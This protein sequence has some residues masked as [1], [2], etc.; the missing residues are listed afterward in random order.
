MAPSLS[1][2]WL[3]VTATSRCPQVLL[4]VPGGLRVSPS[5]LGCPQVP[6]GVLGGLG[7][8]PS[9]LG[10]FWWSRGVPKSSGVSPNP[11]QVLGGL[12]VSPS[13]LGVSPNPLGCPQILSG[14]SG[15][16]RV[17]P[18]PSVAV[19]HLG[20]PGWAGGGLGG[21]H[22]G[23]GGRD[24]LGTLR[25]AGAP[26]RTLGSPWGPSPGTRGAQGDPQDIGGPTEKPPR[27]PRSLQVT[28]GAPQD[29][30]VTPQDTGVTPGDT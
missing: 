29:L 3:R 1:P 7:V 27:T 24:T 10:G 12:G 15:G 20:T 23:D 2:K 16:L 13:H 9:P 25:T 8:S 22:E 14:V 28:G 4:G 11:V 21:P 5:P 30:G 18:S 19:T 26:L 17:S 6:L